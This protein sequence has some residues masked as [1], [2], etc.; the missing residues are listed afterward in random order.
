VLS[1]KVIKKA[2]QRNK[3]KRQIRNALLSVAKQTQVG[4]DVVICVKPDIALTSFAEIK[5]EITQALI[6]IHFL[7]N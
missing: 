4:Y 6:K 5:K 3:K 1:N 2:V 7:K